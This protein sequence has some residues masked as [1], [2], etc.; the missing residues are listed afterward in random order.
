MN[1]DEQGLI[2]ILETF[3]NENIF[4]KDMIVYLI[5]QLK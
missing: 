2:Y 1:G 5:D 3:I 4:E